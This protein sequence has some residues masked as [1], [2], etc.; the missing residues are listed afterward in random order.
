MGRKEMRN[1]RKKQRSKVRYGWLAVIANVAAVLGSILA[2][3]EPVETEG[4]QMK[5][6]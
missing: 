5:R 2:F 4:R 6:C 1:K 3:S